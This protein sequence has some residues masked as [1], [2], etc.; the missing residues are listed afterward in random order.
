MRNASTKP[1][2]WYRIT[3]KA[4]GE[5]EILIYDEISDPLF[6]KFGIGMSALSF[7]KELRALGDV[8]VLNI[9]INSPGGEVFD[10]Q[11]IYSLLRDHKAAKTVY[12]DGIAASIASVIAMAGDKIVM[13]QNAMLMIH[14]PSALCWGTPADMRKMAEDLDKVAESIVAV[15]ARK[16]GKDPAEI[17]QLMAEETWMTAADA[18]ELGFAD[19]QTP[20]VEMAARF[21]LSRFRHAPAAPPPKSQPEPQHEEEPMDITVD[22]VKDKVPS[23]AAHF[24]AEGKKEGEKA[25]RDR[26]A[27]IYAAMLPGQEAVARELVAAGVSVEE[28]AKTFKARKLGEITEAAPKTTGGGGGQE[29]TDLSA[30]SGDELFKVEWAQ[31]KDGVQQEF[32]DAP[33][34]LAFRRAEASGRARI[35]KK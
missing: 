20:A 2:P 1:R 12:V 11:A 23:V 25:E 29:G 16:T 32:T 7:A 22:A 28:A 13:P 9:R 19:E 14:E 8:K 18:I 5:A 21:D 26:V 4:E 6:E 15:Y 35:L 10:G 31:N 24:T 3:A 34:Y 30:L 27:G 17:K 33:S